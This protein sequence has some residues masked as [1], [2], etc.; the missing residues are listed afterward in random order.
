MRYIVIENGNVVDVVVDPPF[1]WNAPAGRSLLAHETAEVGWT[2]FAGVVG[3]PQTFDA[4]TPVPQFL[5]P[6]AAAAAEALNQ[7][8]ATGKP[9]DTAVE[10][11]ST[12]PTVEPPPVVNP[13]PAPAPIVNLEP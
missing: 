5:D 11:S 13:E 2:Y 1:E 6:G 4:D 7:A 9:V 8:E 12:Q 3:P 10:L